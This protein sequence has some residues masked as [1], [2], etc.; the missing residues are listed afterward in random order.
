MWEIVEDIGYKDHLLSVYRY[1]ED[2]HVGGDFKIRVREG[3][4]L[5]E[6]GEWSDAI[7]IDYCDSFKAALDI[8]RAFVI[9]ILTGRGDG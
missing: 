5:D 9:G 3:N 1:V 7:Y 6:G 8:G 4:G 2:G